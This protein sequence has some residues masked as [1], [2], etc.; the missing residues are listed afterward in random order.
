M[1]RPQLVPLGELGSP[2]RIQPLVETIF[3]G[4]RKPGWFERKLVRECVDAS[5]S[6]VAVVGDPQDPAAWIGYVLVGRP[7]S[8]WPRAR[9]AGTGVLASHRRTGVA[10]ALLDDV[11][12]ACRVAGAHTLELWAERSLEPF[13]AACGF[14]AERRL[15]TL[16]ARGRGVID[17]DHTAGAWDEARAI[18]APMIEIH[19][20]LRE[21]WE[22]TATDERRTLRIDELGAVMHVTSE[23]DAWAIHRTCIARPAVTDPGVTDPA[24]T[25]PAFVDV[26]ARVFDAA[27]DRLPHGDAVFA[28]A[29][30]EP[31]VV[32][33]ITPRLRAQG[34]LEAQRA[35]V[36]V[37]ALLDNRTPATDDA[38]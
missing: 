6:R 25:D 13:Y 34:W 30:P 20:W 2:S 29:L 1:T 22:R 12:Q 8:S 18:G 38:G 14:V 32:S 7:P 4:T 15:V 27:L 21:A 19:S 5:L 28:V 37:R 31:S 10:R 35:T 16:V 17:G 23:H 11:A 9:A 26:A 33:S 24:V 36:L 3:G